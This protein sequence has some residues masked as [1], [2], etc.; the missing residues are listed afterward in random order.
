MQVTPPPPLTPP[1]TVSVPLQEYDGAKQ[2]LS[3]QATSSSTSATLTVSVTSTSH[4]G[5]PGRSVRSVTDT[6]AVERVS[7][8]G[9]LL[10][11]RRTSHAQTA[12]ARLDAGLDHGPGVGAFDWPGSSQTRYQNHFAHR[13]GADYYHGHPRP[14]GGQQFQVIGRRRRPA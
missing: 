4:D 12:R 6:S 2:I 5:N 13:R 1:D 11:R 3:V 9:S 14:G 7:Y 8:G 10:L